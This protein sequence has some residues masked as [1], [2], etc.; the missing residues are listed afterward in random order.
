MNLPADKLPVVALGAACRALNVPEIAVRMDGR[1]QPAALA[2]Q[3]S[4]WL[5][6]DVV[7]WPHSIIAHFAGR[8]RS[9]VSHGVAAVVDRMFTEP[10][11]LDKLVVARHLLLESLKEAHP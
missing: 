10:S 6:D 9:A 4:W 8:D 5:L 2:R 7:G 3:V 11:I 1:T